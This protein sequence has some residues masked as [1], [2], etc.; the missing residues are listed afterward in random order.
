MKYVIAATCAFVL[1]ACAPAAADQYAGTWSIDPSSQAGD[2]QLQ[3]RYR[4]VTATGT[5]EWDESRAVSM[6][7]LRGFSE[8]DLNSSGEHK[9]FAI[10]RDAGT[11]QA[12]GWISNR[13]GGGTWTYQPNSSF[14][15]QLRSRGIDA[16]TEKQ[17]FELTLSGFKFATLDALLSA[18]FE[19][20]SIGEIVSMMD[21]GVSDT[22]INGI[23]GV[24]LHPKNVE[25]LIRMRDHGV[26]VNFAATV[27]KSMPSASVED[28]ITL[29]DHGVSERYMAALKQ[30]G[31]SVTP[32][33]AASLRDH[34]VSERYIADLAQIGYRP[35][36]SDLVRLAD[37]GVSASFIERLRSH[38]YTRLSVNDLIRLRDSGF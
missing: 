29:R 37:H 6:T 30:Y 19:R 18:G 8:A 21:H 32:M 5:E 16:P 4:Q 22:Y 17:Q 2:V 36:A 13:H 28:L 11:L 15:A 35:S 25:S 27:L 12:D 3:V 14:D 31:Y 24:G 34:G 1:A 7:E 23:R 20:P 33:E 38:G 26:S 9:S 10:V